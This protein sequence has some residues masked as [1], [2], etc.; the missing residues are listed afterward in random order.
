[1]LNSK[2]LIFISIILLIGLFVTNSAFSYEY[3]GSRWPVSD[4]PVPYYINENGTPDCAGEFAAVI[5][6]F[7]TWEDVS[8]AYMDFTYQGTTAND[9][10]LATDGE[11]VCGWIENDWPYDHDWIAGCSAWDTDGDGLFDEFGIIFNGDDFTFSASG[12]DDKMDVQNI[13][14]HEAGHT[15]KLLDLYGNDDKDKTMYGYSA[16][17]ETKKRSLHQ[18]DEDGIIFI[19]P[20]LC[21]AIYDGNGGPLTGPMPYLLTCDVEVPPD[22]TLTVQPPATVYFQ[23]GFKITANGTLNVSG[24]IRLL[25][26]NA[27]DCGMRLRIDKDFAL[28]NGGEFKLGP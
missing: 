22:Q 17:G 24:Y 19:Y 10:C 21:G 15:L 28:K 9:D 4:L 7:Q 5:N 11:N 2:Q 16:L 8:T 20:A 6:S 26:K 12:E 13:A 25:R 3:G 27:P 23:P 14:T 1:M 18:D